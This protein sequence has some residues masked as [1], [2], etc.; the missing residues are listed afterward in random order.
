MVVGGAEAFSLTLE[1]PNSQ[2]PTPK[3]QIPSQRPAKKPVRAARARDM[4]PLM[5]R[6]DSL[7][8]ALAVAATATVMAN[9]VRQAPGS[10]PF[11]L[12][13]ANGRVMDPESGLDAVRHIGVRDGRIDAVSE[14][15]L[16]GRETIDAS[17]LVVAPGFIDLHVHGHDAENDRVK[18]LDGVTT[19]LELEIGTADVDA[20]YAARAGRSLL[21][22]GVSSGHIPSRMAVFGDP[23][24]LLPSGNGGRAVATPPQLAD[25]Q[26][27]VRRGLERG[28][29]GVGMGIQYTPAATRWE[30]VETFRAAAAFGRPVFVHVRSF[31][32]G[33]PGS[34]VESFLEVIG[35]AAVTGASLHIVHL[36]SMSLDQTPQTLSLVEG[37]RQR[38]Q[39]VTTEA[40]PY[41]AG[42]TRIESALLDQ[43]EN[44]SDDTL[45]RLQWVATGERLTRETFTQYRRQGGMVILHLNTPQMEAM[46][47]TS[48]LTMIASDGRLE[49]GKGHPRQAGTFGR[50]LGHYVRE[51]RQL[52]LMDALRKMTLM[53]AMRLQKAAPD[54]ERKGRIRPGA[55]ADLVVFDAERVSDR[56]TYEQ[57]AVPTEGFRFVIV[58]GAPVVRQGRV[59]DGVFPGRAARAP[60]R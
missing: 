15:P 17:G 3:S 50:V 28:G 47:V 12:V 36:N 52:G 34:S 26:A 59:V 7:V 4:L 27:R 8:A 32:A 19:A 5:R 58:N 38:G 35:A 10:G 41:S 11:D 1:T 42:M 6:L 33:E 30:I 14:R 16:E 49:A 37:A 43:Y 23:G 44:A 18:V 22:Y 39:D 55:D 21:N 9:Q 53:P 2:L 51:T 40:Y 25:I 45:K 20:W 54:F 31:G 60:A 56:S 46:A 48:P 57:P 13:V 24:T 29:L